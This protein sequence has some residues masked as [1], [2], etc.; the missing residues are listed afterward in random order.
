MADIERVSGAKVSFAPDDGRPMRGVTL[1][2]NDQQKLSAHAQI[3]SLLAL[4]TE[5]H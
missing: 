3:R 2:G 1:K 4:T 5:Q